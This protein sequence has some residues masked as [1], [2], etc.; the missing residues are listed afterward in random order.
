MQNTHFLLLEWFSADLII[1]G[2]LQEQ[3]VLEVGSLQPLF[4]SRDSSQL[5]SVPSCFQALPIR[6]CCSAHVSVSELM[7]VIMVQ[8]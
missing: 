2:C 7:Q 3:S 5:R 6:Y 8:L 4:T 1:P